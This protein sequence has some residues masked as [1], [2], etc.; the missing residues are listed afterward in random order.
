MAV[1]AASPSSTS[2]ARVLYES[3]S[4]LEMKIAAAGHYPDKRNTKGIEPEG[5]EVAKFGDTQYIFVASERGSLVGVYKDTG[6]DPEFVQLLPSGIGPEGLVAIP[7]RG[8]LVTANETDLVEDGGARS[9]VMLYELGDGPAAY[10]MIVSTDDETGKPIGW[11][12]L[13]GL[14]ADSEGSRQALCRLRLGLQVA[15]FHLHH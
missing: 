2:P 5:A 13:S 12:A 4:S 11:G 3:G 6:A 15:T 1:R 14:T 10:P 9:H 7:S 8:L